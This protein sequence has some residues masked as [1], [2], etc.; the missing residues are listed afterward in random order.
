MRTASELAAGEVEDATP[1]APAPAAAASRRLP[2]TRTT[3]VH[4]ISSNDAVLRL[5][6][7]RAL[8]TQSPVLM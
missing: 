4:L 7:R 6:D 3:S 2:G 1:P 5:G 8:S